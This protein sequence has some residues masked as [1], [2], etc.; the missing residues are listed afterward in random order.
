MKIL[1]TSP[2]PAR[3]ANS[4]RKNMPNIKINYQ[5]PKSQTPQNQSRDP[6]QIA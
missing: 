3:T 4:S 1:S 5:S 2:S 6:Y